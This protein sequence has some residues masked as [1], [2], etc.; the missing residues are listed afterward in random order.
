MARILRAGPAC[1]GVLRRCPCTSPARVAIT[2]FNQMAEEPCLRIVTADQVT[3]GVIDPV[4]PDAEATAKQCLADIKS[5][6]EA[7]VRRYAEKFGD[8]AEG[9]PLVIGKDRMKAAFDGLPAAEREM[10]ERTARA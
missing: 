1:W 9:E 6:G 5:G 7:A 10:L 2:H 4:A 3:V 8:V